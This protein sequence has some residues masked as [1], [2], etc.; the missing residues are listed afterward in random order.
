MPTRVWWGV[1]NPFKANSDSRFVPLQTRLCC[2]S[3]CYFSSRTDCREWIPAL[4]DPL[5]PLCNLVRME[6]GTKAGSKRCLLTKQKGA[7]RPASG[8]VLKRCEAPHNKMQLCWKNASP[9]CAEAA[10]LAAE[11]VPSLFAAGNY[12]PGDNR[13]PGM[14]PDVRFLW[15]VA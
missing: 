4:I 15:W 1:T 2:I 6:F 7:L 12:S 5:L 14:A 9:C 13:I 8:T 3:Q 11:T 10:G